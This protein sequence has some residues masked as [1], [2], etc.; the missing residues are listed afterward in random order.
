MKKHFLLAAVVLALVGSAALAVSPLGPPT[1]G[2]NQGQ[3]GLAVEYD[4]SKA[5]L[6]VEGE[7]LKNVKTNTFLLKPAYGIMDIWEAYVSIGISKTQITDFDGS[8]EFAWGLGTKYTFIKDETL[9]WG[10]LFNIDWRRSNDNVDGID[11]DFDYYDITI[12]VGPTWKVADNFHVYGGPFFYFLNGEIKAAGETFDVEEKSN[13][14]A[15]IGADLE[16][17]TNTTVFGEFQF[18]GNSGVFGTGVKWKF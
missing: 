16:I 6:T 15:Y 12:A 10:A 4:Y 2:L 7:T 8:N 18:T 5:D 13:L 14:G 1:A 17:C 11:T 9:S 3:F